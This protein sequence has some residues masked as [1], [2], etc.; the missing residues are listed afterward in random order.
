MQICLALIPPFVAPCTYP[1]WLCCTA[2]SNFPGATV[3]LPSGFVWMLDTTAT[4]HSTS[5]LD[6]CATHTALAYW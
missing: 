2:S 5:G 4:R 1:E 6:F 3:V